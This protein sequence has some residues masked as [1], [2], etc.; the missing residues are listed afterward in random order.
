MANGGFFNINGI[1]RIVSDPQVR[2]GKKAS[3]CQIDVAEW[4]TP[5]DDERKRGMIRVSLKLQP[6]QRPP[7]KGMVIH[8]VSGTYHRNP[9]QKDDGDV[10][11][12]HNLTAYVW[13]V[14]PV[15][16]PQ[17]A[18]APA[19]KPAAAAGTSAAKPPPKASLADE[20]EDVPF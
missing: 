3:Y 18:A 4:P 5:P 17:T 6:D 12:F 11:F 16:Q 15:G 7:T 1:G 10:I 8:V 9:S 19:S 13:R 14:L 20:D 2:T